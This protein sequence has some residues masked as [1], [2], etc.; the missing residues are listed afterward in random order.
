LT[1]RQNSWSFIRPQIKSA[2]IQYIFCE[3]LKENGC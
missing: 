1:S 3:K 2:I